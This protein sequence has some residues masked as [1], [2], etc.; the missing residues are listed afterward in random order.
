M[1]VRNGSTSGNYRHRCKKGS[2]R[3]NSD[4]GGSKNDIKTSKGKEIELSNVI[5]TK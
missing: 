2:Q 5:N 4:T 1:L 3:N